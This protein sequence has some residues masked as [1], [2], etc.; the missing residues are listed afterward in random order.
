MKEKPRGRPSLADEWLEDA[1]VAQG[2]GLTRREQAVYLD[3]FWRAI[4]AGQPRLPLLAWVRTELEAR[5][6]REYAR[7][8]VRYMPPLDDWAPDRWR[9]HAGQCELVGNDRIAAEARQRA[10]EQELPHAVEAMVRKLQQWDGKTKGRNA[11][12][13]ARLAPHF[14]EIGPPVTPSATE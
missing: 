3:D 9:W 10:A 11:E 8:V 12:H 5:D 2:L 13:V 14:P 6:P 7:S 4:E 1:A